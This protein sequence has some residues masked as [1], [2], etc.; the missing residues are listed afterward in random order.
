MEGVDLFQQSTSL[1]CES[2][3]SKAWSI[4]YGGKSDS[5]TQIWHFTAIN[6]CK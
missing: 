3:I 5:D 6:E 4:I 2:T 1:M